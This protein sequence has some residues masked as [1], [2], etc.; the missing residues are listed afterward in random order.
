MQKLCRSPCPTGSLVTALTRGTP[1]RWPR[2]SR[3]LHQVTAHC[4]LVSTPNRFGNDSNRRALIVEPLLGDRLTGVSYYAAQ[5][6][7][8]CGDQ[9]LSQ[10]Q[11]SVENSL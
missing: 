1:R 2:R 6:L 11:G 10:V 8:P 4:G 5:E 3:T 7:D 9:L